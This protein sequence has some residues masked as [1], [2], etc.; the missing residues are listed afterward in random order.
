MHFHNYITVMNFSYNNDKYYLHSPDLGV[1]AS[2][3][4]QEV[5]TYTVYVRIGK[6]HNKIITLLLL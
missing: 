6:M 1:S 5:N 3:S 2:R 4:L